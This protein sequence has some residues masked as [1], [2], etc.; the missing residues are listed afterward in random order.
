[1]AARLKAKH[2]DDIRTKIQ[3]SNLITRVQKYALGELDDEDISSNRLNA[4][5]MLLA[6]TLPDLSSVTISGDNENPLQI[7]VAIEFVK[8]SGKVS[9]KP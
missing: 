7:G 5:K 3:V 4:I 1:M 2:Q 8:G 6:K 9:T